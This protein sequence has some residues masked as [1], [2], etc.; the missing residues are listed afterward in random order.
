MASRIRPHRDNGSHP[1]PIG[2][3]AIVFSHLGDARH[4]P[5]APRALSEGASPDYLTSPFH[6]GG[7][8][9]GGPRS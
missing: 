3:A 6:S 1:D 9:S 4:D 2:M 5:A 8:V 7:P